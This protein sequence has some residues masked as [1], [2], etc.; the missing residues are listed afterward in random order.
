MTTAAPFLQRHF[1]DYLLVA[2]LSEDPLGT[3]F[4]ALYAVDERRFVRLRI[5]RAEDLLPEPV[6]ATVARNAGGLGRIVHDA[7][8]ARPQLDSVDDMP[9][10]TW[11]ETGGWTLDT[12]LTRV[13]SFGSGFRRSTRS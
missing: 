12:M 11:D 10:M 3:V 8:V 1:G 13:R 2:Q 6:D 5:L 4:R 9:F 7:L